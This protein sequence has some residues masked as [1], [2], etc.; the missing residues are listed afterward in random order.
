[1]FFWEVSL[2]LEDVPKPISESL[3]ILALVLMHTELPSAFG[4]SPFETHR[5]IGVS[6]SLAP[7]LIK[8]GESEAKCENGN[9]APIYQAQTACQAHC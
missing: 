7:V 8:V 2:W 6:T 3:S 4:Q 5:R 9:I 1:M